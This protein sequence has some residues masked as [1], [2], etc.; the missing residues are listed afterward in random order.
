[1]TELFSRTYEPKL[2]LS[3]AA[4]LEQALE[5]LKD[6]RE[7]YRM[8]ETVLPEMLIEVIECSTSPKKQMAEDMIEMLMD[9]AKLLSAAYENPSL[10]SAYQKLRD[11][12]KPIK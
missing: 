4:R 8:A 1:M 7:L 9:K 5:H 6:L 10:Q 11:E 3:E 2:T 12:L